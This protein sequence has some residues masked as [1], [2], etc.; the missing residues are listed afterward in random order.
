M[1]NLKISSKSIFIGC[2]SNYEGVIKEKRESTWIL[3]SSCCV[4]PSCDAV[5]RKLTWNQSNQIKAAGPPI[6]AVSQL[7]A[8]RSSGYLILILLPWTKD[9]ALGNGGKFFWYF[10]IFFSTNRN[11]LETKIQNILKQHKRALELFWVVEVYL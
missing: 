10:H 5:I 6:T 4:F 7:S 1:N 11:D 3:Q 8:Y 2:S 9:P